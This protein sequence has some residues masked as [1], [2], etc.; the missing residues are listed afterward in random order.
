[1]FLPGA[2]QLRRQ[3]P[4]PPGVPREPERTLKLGEREAPAAVVAWWREEES[5]IK[6][7]LVDANAMGVE[8]GHRAEVLAAG[9]AEV[10]TGRPPSLVRSLRTDGTDA[11]R[12]V[13]RVLRGALARRGLC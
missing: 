11:H 7:V 1:G 2:L 10:Q 8:R 6:C 12:V 4:R 3:A 9:S 13:R 5:F